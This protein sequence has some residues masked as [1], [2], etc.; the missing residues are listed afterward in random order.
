METEEGESSTAISVTRLLNRAQSTARLAADFSRLCS[1]YYARHSGEGGAISRPSSSSAV[2]EMDTEMREASGQVQNRGSADLE[3]A[4]PEELRA[5]TSA[6]AQH[7]RVL[8]Y[9]QQHAEMGLFDMRIDLL[10][11]REQ[12][13]R[14][15]SALVEAERKLYQEDADKVSA[16]N[17]SLRLLSE[18]STYI[19]AVAKTLPTS[20]LATMEE[21]MNASTITASVDNKAKE[22]AEKVRNLLAALRA[23]ADLERRSA[24]ISRR[25]SIANAFP[26]SVCKS[27]HNLEGEACMICL[28]NFIIGDGVRTPPCSHVFHS[29]CLKRWMSVKLSCPLCQMEWS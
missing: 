27:E 10:R 18:G 2:Y 14:S 13:L 3:S 8:K 28:D 22:I 6:A 17:L 9:E 25:L 5:C 11:L 20:A 7:L 19:E 26:F 29:A 21:F 15:L 1:S 23:G 4:T 24:E 12:N 16:C